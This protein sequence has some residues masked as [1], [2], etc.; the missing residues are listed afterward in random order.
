[1]L[2]DVAETTCPYCGQPITLRVDVSA[3]SQSYIEDCPVCCQ[4]INVEVNVDGDGD[5]QVGVFRD[6]T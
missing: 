1:M 6:D 3:G 2:E 4:P 5:F